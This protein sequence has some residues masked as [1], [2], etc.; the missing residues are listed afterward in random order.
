MDWRP[1]AACLDEDPELFFPDGESPR[2]AHQIEA[3]RQVCAG[4]AVREPCLD[5]ALRTEQ[6]G[7][8]WAGTTP[9][10]RTAL[11]RRSRHHLAVGS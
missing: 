9:G 4:C 1:Q 2:Y 10:Q 5:F 8:I 6:N 3:A 11:R 7:G